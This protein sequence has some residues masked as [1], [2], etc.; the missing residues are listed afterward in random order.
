MSAENTTTQERG[1]LEQFLGMSEGYVLDFSDRTFGDFVF[2]AAGKDIHSENYT[3]EGTSKA[4]KLR[5]LRL[6]L[7]ITLA[8]AIVRHINRVMGTSLQ[9]QTPHP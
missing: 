2:E 7:H 3:T 9:P 8:H 4:K 6:N 5:A 1:R